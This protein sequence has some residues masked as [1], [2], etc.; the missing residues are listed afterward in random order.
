M[1]HF[2][3]HPHLLAV[4]GTLKAAHGNHTLLQRY[5]SKLVGPGYTRDMVVLTDS[6]PT[7]HV[8]PERLAHAYRDYFGHLKVEVY[9]V[10]DDGLAA[11]D[12]LEGHP[13]FYCREPLTINIGTELI[14]KHVTAWVYIIVRRPG[15]DSLQKPRDG[16]LEWGRDRKREARDFQRENTY[17]YRA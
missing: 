7:A 3:E 6:F 15:L 8:V 17:K 9:R 14:P 1:D 10:S 5:D 4:Y 16:F 11:C 13:S 12:R 2:K